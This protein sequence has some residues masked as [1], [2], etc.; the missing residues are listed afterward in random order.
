MS[1]IDIDWKPDSKKLKEFG[2]VSAIGF[3]VIGFLVLPTVARLHNRKGIEVEGELAA[4]GSPLLEPYAWM[5]WNWTI[6]FVLLGIG[7]LIWI[8]SLISTKAVKPIYLFW[9][10]VA[11]PIGWCISHLIL[12]LLY[13]GLFTPMAL[14]FKLTGRDALAREID[15]DAKSYWV[16]REG[17]IPNERYVR[18]F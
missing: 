14:F 13:F 17:K 16:E 5:D 18:Q 3:A 9:M 7:L 8:I 11:F 1:A 4:D 12:G 15:K 6:S 2:W 10:A